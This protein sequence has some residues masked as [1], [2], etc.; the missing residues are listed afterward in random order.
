MVL[1]ISYLSPEGELA[2]AYQPSITDAELV[3]GY[4]TMLKMRI[5]EQ[6]LIKLQRQGTISFAMSGLGE[7]AS[8]V[9]SAAAC[10]PED[11]LFPQY[12]ESGIMFW[13]GFSIQD[14][15]HL[16]F[17]NAKDQ[18]LGRQMPNHFGCSKLNVVTVSSP[19]ATQLPQAAGTAYAMMLQKEPTIALTYFGEGSTSKE[20]FAVALNFAALRK[21]PVIFFCRNNQY[22]ISTPAAEQFTT[23]GIAPK[24]I[25][26]N[27]QTFC[28]DGNDYFAVHETVS[29]ARAL[30]LEGK[31]PV[32]IEAITYRLGAHSTSDDPTAYRN[33]AE[34]A[35]WEKKDPLLRLHRYLQAKNLWSDEQE[36]L[37][38]QKIRQELD[39]AI[40]EAKRTPPPPLAT[41]ITDV[42]FEPSRALKKQLEEVKA[43]FAEAK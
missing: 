28:V 43:L 10:T 40:E 39:T 16:M 11:W 42:T 15:A 30:C 26:Y 13:R 6:Q 1:M 32:L 31:G 34:V 12:R 5:V 25:A 22:A 21:T 24:G 38:E 18:N 9:A 20:D 2:P 35:E 33:D 23:E 14:Y 29:K 27:I 4:E 3:R 17:C 36:A 37:F 19:L 8:I 7:E 41:L